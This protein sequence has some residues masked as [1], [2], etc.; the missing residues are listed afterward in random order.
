MQHVDAAATAAL[1]K[2]KRLF[3]LL[4]RH[5]NALPVHLRLLREPL[6]QH[7]DELNK[8]TKL[9][10]LFQNLDVDPPM[11]NLVNLTRKKKPNERFDVRQ[12]ALL[13][14]WDYDRS[15]AGP[16]WF[17]LFALA[18]VWHLTAC[19][20]PEHFRRVVLR[21]AKSVTTLAPPP[22]WVSKALSLSK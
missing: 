4:Q 11:R 18:R 20:D 14:W 7:L 12:Q 8:F 13:W 5:N 16:N 17:D 10:A 22:Q 1:K 9:L 21:L 15:H 6:L 3:E 19:K 2:G